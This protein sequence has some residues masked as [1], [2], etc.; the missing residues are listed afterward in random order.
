MPGRYDETLEY[1]LEQCKSFFTVL[2]SD[3]ALL[4]YQCVTTVTVFLTFII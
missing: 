2:I 1:M 4:N 3:R